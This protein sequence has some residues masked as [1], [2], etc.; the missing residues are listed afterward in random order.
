M[1]VLNATSVSIVAERWRNCC[2]AFTKNPR[3]SQ[4]TTGADNSAIIAPPQGISIKNIPIT[5]TGIAS[6]TAQKA[7]RFR[8]R[9]RSRF[10]R[11]NSSGVSSSESA[12]IS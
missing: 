10:I 7:R 5:T 12:S 11:S 8:S 2:Q 4:K 6:T 1:P 3:P 9:Y